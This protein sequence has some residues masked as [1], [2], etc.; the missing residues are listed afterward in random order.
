MSLGY[1]CCVDWWLN[2]DSLHVLYPSVDFSARPPLTYGP[3]F[4]VTPFPSVASLI[5]FGSASFQFTKLHSLCI[6]QGEGKRG[7]R[8]FMGNLKLFGKG[9]GEWPKFLT[10][11]GRGEVLF[12]SPLIKKRKH[13]FVDFFNLIKEDHPSCSMLEESLLAH[14]LYKYTPYRIL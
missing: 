12:F 9:Q 10:D 7:Q 6:P 8:V 14:L 4:P 5:H 2:S 1:L 13:Y 11:E 3:H